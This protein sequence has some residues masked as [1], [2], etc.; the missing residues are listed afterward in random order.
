MGELLGIPEWLAETLFVSTCLI[1]VFSYAGISIARS[2]KRL[3]A[4]RTNPTQAEFLAL[5]RTDVREDVAR[6]LWE[7]ALPYVEPKLTPHP[8]D[9][10]GED[11]C[12][13]DDDWGM[14]W[15]LEWA[16]R[17]GFHEG[18]LPDWP[19]D[20]PATIRNYGRWLSAGPR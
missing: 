17:Q 5:M 10:L 19:K 2:H 18:T 6:F 9:N 11:L 16:R 15:P 1:I 8:D 20:W 14:D 4:R 7:T 3:A 13:D 12:I